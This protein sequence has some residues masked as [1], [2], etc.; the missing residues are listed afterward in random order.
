MTAS[1]IR[2]RLAGAGPSFREGLRVSA[3]SVFGSVARGEAGTESDVDILVDFD[4]PADFDRFMAL[5]ERLE[6]ALG[7]PVDLVTRKA[8]RPEL[9]AAIEREAVVVA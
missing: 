3:V 9:R 8:L 1:D 2:S 7:R 6:A 4:G 5:K